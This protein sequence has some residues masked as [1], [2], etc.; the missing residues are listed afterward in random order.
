ME[1]H[2]STNPILPPLPPEPLGE[3]TPEEALAKPVDQLLKEL[4]KQLPPATTDR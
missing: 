1:I 3:T 4:D 2:S